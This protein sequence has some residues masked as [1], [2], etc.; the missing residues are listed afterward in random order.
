M[1]DS[2][3]WRATAIAALAAGLLGAN[4]A[5]AAE[6]A[7]TEAEALS[8]LAA[9]NENEIGVSAEAIKRNIA[10][11][12][13]SFARMM[14]KDHKENLEKTQDLLEKAGGPSD[15]KA[16]AELRA[17]GL[18]ELSTLAPLDGEQFS[19][20]YMEIMVKGHEKVLKTLDESLKKGLADEAVRKHFQETREKVAAHLERA[21]KI[22]SDREG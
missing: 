14:E 5:R 4:L 13:M 10:P 2:A 15:G 21:K 11:D 18:E 17:Q 9:I 16:V 7:K 1:N 20:A 3:L 22:R 12:V 19:D 8:V 6:P